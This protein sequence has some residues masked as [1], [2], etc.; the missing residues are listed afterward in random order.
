[1]KLEAEFDAGARRGLRLR[2]R[3][4]IQGVPQKAI[5]GEK[6]VLLSRLRGEHRHLLW[7]HDTACHD[8][9]RS[10]VENSLSNES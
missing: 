4:K 10:K 8:A 7:R 9:E 2:F 3:L 1:M 6:D 5:G